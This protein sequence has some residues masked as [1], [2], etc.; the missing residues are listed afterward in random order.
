MG[1]FSTVRHFCCSV[2]KS[3]P[4]PAGGRGRMRNM[5]GRG[6]M[7]GG[8]RGGRGGSRGR[9]GRGGKMGGDND[10]DGYGEEMEVSAFDVRF[11]FAVDQW[12]A[13]ICLYLFSMTMI[14]TTLGKRIMTT[15]STRGP[16]REGEVSPMYNFSVLLLLFLFVF[17]CQ[18]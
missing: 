13:L 5:R 8:R 18:P 16:K 4:V 2:S 6:G 15:I 14:M 12:K 10:G 1:N 9:G 11:F 3:H 7:R 17:N